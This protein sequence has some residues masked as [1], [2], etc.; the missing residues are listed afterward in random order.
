MQHLQPNNSLSDIKDPLICFPYDVWLNCICFAAYGE[1]D[2]PLPL[3][4]VSQR[5]RGSIIEAPE[6]WTSIV[7]DSGEDTLARVNVLL[8]FSKNLPIDLH[9]LY[10]SIL[11]EALKV[12]LK[13]SSRIRAIIVTRSSMELPT[14]LPFKEL[15]DLL[16]HESMAYPQMEEFIVGGYEGH[17]KYEFLRQCPKLVRVRFLLRTTSF[18]VSY[19]KGALGKQIE[20]PIVLKDIDDNT[21]LDEVPYL[22]SLDLENMRGPDKAQPPFRALSQHLE[23]LT[24]YAP[25]DDQIGSFLNTIYPRLHS[26]TIAMSPAAI[27]A[28]IAS[29]HLFP[30]LKSLH[31]Y[32]RF[33]DLASTSRVLK[34]LDGPQ[35]HSLTLR[36]NSLVTPDDIENI[37]DDLAQISILTHA[38]LLTVRL[39]KSMGTA[40]LVKL[41]RTAP[42]IQTL[43]IYRPPYRG[44]ATPLSV[45]LPRLEILNVSSLGDFWYLDA[46]N[47]HSLSVSNPYVQLNFKSEWKGDKLRGLCTDSGSFNQLCNYILQSEPQHHLFPSLT[48]IKWTTYDLNHGFETTRLGSIK[49]VTF[50]S[51][52][53]YDGNYKMA[54]IDAFCVSILQHPDVCPDLETITSRDYPCWDLFLQVLQLRNDNSRVKNIKSVDLPGYPVLAI[55]QALI[56]TL[57]GVGD[58]VKLFGEI[59]EV[60]QTRL[61]L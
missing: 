52:A 57:S 3:L 24:Y 58:K 32:L 7:I 37:M 47:L 14:T 43:A 11:W 18:S 2:G 61:A 41:L 42:Q 17:G 30:S 4:S 39:G 48:Y 26:L 15:L 54:S 27:Q 22:T 34:I 10:P 12:V 59:E 44:N 36:S 46:P 53:V 20:L 60:I 50:G 40:A 28:V 29:I 49:H 51:P 16:G 6:A 1:V 38:R 19:L 13:H 23:V 9:I 25:R 8:H 31:I 56:H 5:W 21:I 33:Q 45:Y 35:L 55:L